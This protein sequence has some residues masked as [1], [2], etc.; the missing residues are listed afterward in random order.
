MNQELDVERPR[1]VI[2]GMA[3]HPRTVGAILS[4]VCAGIQVVASDC[5]PPAHGG[6]SRHVNQRLLIEPGSFNGSPLSL[7]QFSATMFPVCH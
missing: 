1:G 3:H 4:L 2:L 5:K 6:Y 7:G